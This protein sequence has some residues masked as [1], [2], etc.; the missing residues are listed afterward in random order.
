M[1]GL[2]RENAFP[3][4]VRALARCNEGIIIFWLAR[5]ISISFGR[6]RRAGL[7]RGNRDAKTSMRET[8]KVPLKEL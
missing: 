8:S 1:Q 7:I 2:G 5:Y 4:S 3:H 6:S